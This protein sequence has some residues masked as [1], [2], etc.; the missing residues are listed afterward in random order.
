M[1]RYVLLPIFELGKMSS[2]SKNR[3]GEGISKKLR[4]HFTPQSTDSPQHAPFLSLTHFR[5]MFMTW[6]RF[7]DSFEQPRPRTNPRTRFQ[8]TFE[9]PSLPS[10]ITDAPAPG[11]YQPT[12]TMDSPHAHTNKQKPLTRPLASPVP[13]HLWSNG[14][15][16]SQP[17]ARVTQAEKTLSRQKL[18]NLANHRTFTCATQPSTRVESMRNQLQMALEAWMHAV[19]RSF[20]TCSSS[21]SPCVTKV[22]IN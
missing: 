20:T 19:V 6:H 22:L 12:T 5:W 18:K 11:R 14:L 4:H 3:S 9:L 10:I 13:L 21:L 1:A 17:R 16:R 7:H 2:P 15:W 8:K